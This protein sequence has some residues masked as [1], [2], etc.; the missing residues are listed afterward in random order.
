MNREQIKSLGNMTR[1]ELIK[2][3]EDYLGKW[4]GDFDKPLDYRM[5]LKRLDKLIQNK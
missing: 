3:R 4:M 1:D 5:Q 2:V